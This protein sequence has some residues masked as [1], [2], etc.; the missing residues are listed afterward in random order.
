[1]EPR[2]RRDGGS[3]PRIRELG[4]TRRFV[5]NCTLSGKLK[6]IRA[7]HKRSFAHEFAG[8]QTPSNFSVQNPLSKSISKAIRI[9]KEKRARDGR[10]CRAVFNKSSGDPKMGS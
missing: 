7:F 1:M 6:E 5:Q 4:V 3:A 8:G 2:D 10:P 9:W